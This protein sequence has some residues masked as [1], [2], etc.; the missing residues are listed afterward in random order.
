MVAQV[1][2]LP[3]PPLPVPPVVPVLPIE[4]EE[5]GIQAPVMVLTAAQAAVPPFAPL[6][7]VQKLVA[8]LSVPISP[9][10]EIQPPGT[11][12]ASA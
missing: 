3:V 5:A 6:G 2:P 7:R 1:L 9:F 12:C 8:T 10:K 4:T 11:F